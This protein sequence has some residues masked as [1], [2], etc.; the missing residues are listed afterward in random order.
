MMALQREYIS[1]IQ[2]H[3]SRTTV[4]DKNL[5]TRYSHILRAVSCYEYHINPTEFDSYTK[6]TA[7]L[8][9]REYPWFYMPVSI[10]RILIHGSDVV[11][12]NCYISYWTTF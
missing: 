12:K 3:F 4:V 9:V 7:R 10:H 6:E 11:K 1:L 8:F 2:R 5:I